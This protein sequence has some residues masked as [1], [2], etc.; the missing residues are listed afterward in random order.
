M[1]SAAVIRTT[2]QDRELAGASEQIYHAG[3]HD[4]IFELGNLAEGAECF[5]RFKEYKATTGS[6]AP[7]GIDANPEEVKRIK[8]ERQVLAAGPAGRPS[9]MGRLSAVAAPVL[10]SAS[11]PARPR[12]GAAL[13]QG[14]RRP[15]ADLPH[16]A[17]A[18]RC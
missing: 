3:A 7:A 9:R 17:G 5:A 13:Q 4:A 14:R 10:L 11:R 2:E 1:A 12:L 6:R 15:R 18:R 8:S 16:F